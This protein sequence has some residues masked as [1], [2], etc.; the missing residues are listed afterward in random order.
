M[1]N[2]ERVLNMIANAIALYG[3]SRVLAG[4][5]GWSLLIFGAALTV[6]CIGVCARPADSNT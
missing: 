1:I 6:I 3:L 4:Q 5:G 2:L